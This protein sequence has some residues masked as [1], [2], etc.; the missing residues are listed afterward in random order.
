MARVFA[1]HHDHTV[2]ADHL[3]LIADRLNARLDLHRIPFDC[4][5]ITGEIR[6]SL[7]YVGE[8]RYPFEHDLNAAR[9]DVY[10]SG[11]L[12]T[13]DDTTSGKVVGA[14]FH[15]YSVLRQDAN[16]V[17]THLA[18]DVCENLVA[19]IQLNTEHRVGQSF[20]HRAFNLD[21]AVFLSHILR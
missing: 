18:R 19:V 10:I 15:Y 21:D 14:Q 13:V 11:L 12:V 20:N 7:T 2:T 16:V 3:A 1:D 17:L 5:L 4:N 6:G 9:G 8:L